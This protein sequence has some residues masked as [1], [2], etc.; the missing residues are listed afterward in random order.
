MPHPKDGYKLNG[1]SVPGVTTILNRFKESGALIHWAW[2]Q[3]MEGRDYREAKQ[4]AADAGTLA[5]AMIE[6][7]IRGRSFTMPPGTAPDIAER[8]ERAFAAF[9]RWAA[10]FRFE[11]RETEVSLVSE[12]HRF[13]G[14]LDVVALDGGLCIGDFKTSKDIYFDHLLQLGGYSVLWN[15]AHPDRPVERGF[16][17][18]VREEDFEFRDFHNL[19]PAQDHFLR[20]VEVWYSEAELKRKF[21]GTP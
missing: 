16:I 8:A 6:A 18:R 20:L 10:T 3:G 7:H 1:R 17:L 13:G 9:L 11:P 14:T 15:E 19:R 4:A 2:K 5:H 21:F 12:K